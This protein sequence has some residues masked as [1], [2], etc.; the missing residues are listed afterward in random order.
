MYHGNREYFALK[1][2]LIDEAKHK[3]DGLPFVCKSN[4]NSNEEDA[5]IKRRRMNSMLPIKIPPTIKQ[6][7]NQKPLN[8][9]LPAANLVFVYEWFDNNKDVYGYGCDS[10]GN[11]CRIQPIV[12]PGLFAITSNFYVLREICS[13]YGYRVDMYDIKYKANNFALWDFFSM[14][15]Y[16]YHYDV[17]IDVKYIYIMVETFSLNL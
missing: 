16:I 12:E 3:L 4:I 17:I 10:D 5:T 2:Q 6:P 7:L 11:A 9:E 14:T 8:E 13:L 15:I 1:R